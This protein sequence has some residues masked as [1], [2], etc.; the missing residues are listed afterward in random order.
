MKRYCPYCGFCGNPVS[1]RFCGAC[2]AELGSY[3]SPQKANAI[4][5]LVN[6]IKNYAQKRERKIV[7]DRNAPCPC[8]SGLKFKNCH[9]RRLY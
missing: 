3:F 4:S 7:I 9:G 1:A 8:G 5:S 6:G 2:G